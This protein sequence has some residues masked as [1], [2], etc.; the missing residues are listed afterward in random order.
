MK[1]RRIPLDVLRKHAVWTFTED[2]IPA[3]AAIAAMSGHVV[4][5]EHLQFCSDDDCLLKS[6]TS[7][8]MNIAGSV[9]KLHGAYMYHDRHRNSWRRVGKAAGDGDNACFQGRHKGHMQSLRS[10]TQSEFYHKFPLQ[11]YVNPAFRDL[12]EGLFDK[13]AHCVAVAF[14]PQKNEPGQEYR[15]LCR[16]I[17]KGGILT[18]SEHGERCAQCMR[19]AT[20]QSKRAELA[21]YLFECVYGLMLA[22]KDNVSESMGYEPIMI[23]AMGKAKK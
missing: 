4:G 14:Y 5:I 18:W 2:N 15:K 16:D 1:Q 11:D 17:R 10:K 3:V 23:P 8:F 12:Q 20:P 6:D 22:P 19:S 9:G 7:C 21:A 13:L